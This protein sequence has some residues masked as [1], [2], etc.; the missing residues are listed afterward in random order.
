MTETNLVAVHLKDINRGEVWVLK[1]VVELQVG[2]E[3]GPL[4]IEG[5]GPSIGFFPPHMAACAAPISLRKGPLW[6]GVT[7][8]SNLET[9][10]N[11]WNELVQGII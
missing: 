3:G 6:A 9:V 2:A 8:S 11:I 7:W 5:V 1:Q 4:G 10:G